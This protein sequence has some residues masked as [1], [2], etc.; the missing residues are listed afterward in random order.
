MT[1][2]KPAGLAILAAGICLLLSPSMTAQQIS[3]EGA[4]QKVGP[5]TDENVNRVIEKLEK[6]PAFR[7]KSLPQIKKDIYKFAEETF[8][9]TPEQ[10]KVMRV[11]VPP[12]LAKVLQDSVVLVL[13]QG[14][15]IKYDSARKEDLKLS[16]TCTA[17]PHNPSKITCVLTISTDP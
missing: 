8:D 14:G 4:M 13:E 16:L 2:K 6:D 12:D 17:D 3:G 1:M 10:Q 11:A 15:T 9:L 5:L 7:K